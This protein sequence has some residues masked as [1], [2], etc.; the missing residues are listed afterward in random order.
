MAHMK[1]ALDSNPQLRVEQLEHRHRHDPREQRQHLMHEP[2]HETD[3]G[4]ADQQEEYEDVERG[5]AF[6]ASGRKLAMK[7]LEK[8][9]R[10]S[11][12]MLAQLDRF[13]VADHLAPASGRVSLRQLPL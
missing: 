1:A 11:I 13:A 10:G 4:A 6:G 7:A 8:A 3:G 12:V 2:A 9:D 5:H